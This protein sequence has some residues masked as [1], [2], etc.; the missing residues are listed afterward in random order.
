MNHTTE[1]TIIL[2]HV[3]N[4]TG[5][6]LIDSVAGSG[7]TT[8]LVAIAKAIKH[9][10]GLMLCYNKSIAMEAS[11]KFPKTTSCST[12]H[13]LAYQA[14]V[15]KYKLKLGSFSYRDITERIKYEEKLDI[16]D[17]IK[18]F[19][20]SKHLTFDEFTAEYSVSRKLVPYIKQ[21]LD[22]M[23]Q[24]KIECTHD[25]YLKLFHIY[26]ASGD[27]QYAPF[28]FI[29]LDE[30][31]DTNEVTLEIFKLLPSERK[32]AVGDPFQNIYTFNHTINCFDVL[33]NE[34]TLFRMSQSFRV[35]D[36]L[37]PRI[38]K[39]CRTYLDPDMTFKGVPITDTTI[40][41][42]GYLTRTNGALISHMIDLIQQ[43]TPF[44]L[45]RKPQEIF[46]L[47]LMLCSL[48][49]Q[50][51][52]TEPAYKHLQVDIDDWYESSDLKDRY[53][54]P[55]SYISSLYNE[56]MQL[57]QA[58][59]LIQRHGKSTILQTYEQARHHL[60]TNQPYVLA[61]AHSCKGLEFD[62]VTLAPD[63][64]DS[65]AEIL[66][67]LKMGREFSSLTVPEQESLNLYYVACTRAA[68]VLNNATHL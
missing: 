40:K 58:I 59:R 56:D 33:R 21:Y 44:G 12:T 60:K 16:I 64:N 63:M 15:K 43:K 25:F 62:E 4:N 50:G 54:S 30:A 45:V 3:Q 27:V 2:N 52:I 29:M 65:I 36:Y 67:S 39:F 31:G 55:L 42:R 53:K 47:P 26:L 9:S 41:T 34:G 14:I 10:N 1:Q 57:T 28:D 8:M 11:R 5:L 7:K 68:K 61:T 20:L 49:Y 38:E 19:C 35:S 37:A 24:G 48:K 18:Q 6:T 46:R 22:K 17:T 13:S 66:L 32:I 23:H 51:F